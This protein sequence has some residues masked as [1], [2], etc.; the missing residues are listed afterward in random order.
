[1]ENGSRVRPRRPA[2]HT[3]VG[4]GTKFNSPARGDDAAISGDEGHG[5]RLNT[6]LPG[7]SDFGIAVVNLAKTTI[8]AGIMAMPRAM[9]LLGILCGTIYV[10]L[11]SA[12]IY[13]SLAVLV[14]AASHTGKWTYR[15]TVEV[16][17]GRTSALLLQLI[18]LMA[19]AG[20]CA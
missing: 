12:V 20:M 18:I 3:A 2:H 9:Q 19:N 1:M 11:L 6:E 4:I 14:R 16:L 13:Y 10:V 8:G 15:G 7:T 17:V 5:S